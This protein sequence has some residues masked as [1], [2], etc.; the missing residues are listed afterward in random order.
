MQGERIDSAHLD[1]L[2]IRGDR[3]WA[4]RD[5]ERGGIRG[6]KKIPGLMRFKAHVRADGTVEVT[7]PDGSTGTAGEASLDE[8]LSASLGRQVRL[9]ALP[10]AENLEHFRRGPS[11][12]SDMLE[13]L[14]AVFGREP[15][16]PL[17]DFSIFPPEIMEFESPP[18]T[19]YDCFPLMIMSTAALAD[20]AA[21]MGPDSSDI[22]RFRP[23]MVLEVPDAVGHPE[24]MWKGRRAKVGEAEVE[25]LDPCPRCVMITHELDER[26]PANRSLMRYVVREL[27][28]NLGVY[29][30][31]TKPGRVDVGDALVWTTSDA[32]NDQDRR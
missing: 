28:Q 26:T 30:R 8:R 23:S 10:D 11:D 32:A 12:G 24:F 7:L 2:G 9:E 31:I 20:V 18:G 6:A 19:Y 3:V 21:A 4:I 29:A 27:D 15:D 1:A 5:L 25:F 22:R 14:R 16:E 17:P 13:E